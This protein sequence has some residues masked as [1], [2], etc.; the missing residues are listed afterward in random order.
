VLALGVDGASP[1]LLERWAL[2]GTLPH[3]GSLIRRGVAGR[4]RSLDGFFVGS[5]WPSFFTGVTPARHGLHYQVQL[6]PG[7]YRY[8]RPAEGAYVR[9]DSFW[10]ALSRAGRRSAV[11]DVPL[12]RLDRGMN[13]IQVV[14]WGSHDPV[15]GFGTW[16]PA[17]EAE[18]TALA[19]AHP[20]GHTCDAERRTAR[21]YQRFTDEMVRGARARAEL[22]RHLL[23]KGGW[24]LFLLVLSEAHCAG[25]QCWHLHDPTHPGHDAAI[26]AA[27]G[28]PIRRVYKAIDAA[29]GEILRDQHGG[30]V[31]VFSLH[32]M[33]HWFGAHF[34]L[35]ELLFRLGAA[36]PVASPATPRDRGPSG[37]ARTA[38][39]QAWHALPTAVR[40]A[41]RPHL[42]KESQTDP[43]P[44]IGVDP[45]RSRCFAVGNGLA[46]SGIRLNRIG[47][48]PRGILAPGAET[49]A[50]CAQLTGELLEIVREDTGRPL[51]ARVLRTSELYAGDRLDDL[52]DLLVDW[53][54]ST[55]T[56]SS[57]LNGGAGSVIRASS[58]RIGVVEGTNRYTRTGEHR[59]EGFFVAA[60]PGI[61]PGRLERPVS[62]LDFAPTFARLL[63]VDLPGGDGLP[64]MELLSGVAP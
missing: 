32:G 45:E 34:L 31:I 14:E 57:E 62:V 24:D 20:S 30:L 12:S 5:T 47:R 15:F 60:G 10:T 38:A 27:T 21:D 46:T 33:S 26:A 39:V 63:G 48:E 9:H 40:A 55:P 11:V 51:V 49:D 1:D 6:E 36:A 53:D 7:S 3:V 28:D 2:D 23:R 43:L 50:F 8:H 56:G 44:T 52:P 37:L 22:G 54:D 16:P 4:T 19:G 41:L 58:P 25:H 61:A 35:P 13:G 17:L 64:V 59:I 42:R 29:I 18:I